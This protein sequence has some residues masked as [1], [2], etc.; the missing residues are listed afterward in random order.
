MTS[1]DRLWLFGSLGLGVA[2]W[3]ARQQRRRDAALLAA[4]TTRPLGPGP[5]DLGAVDPSQFAWPGP[6]DLGPVDPFLFGGTVQPPTIPA[7]TIWDDV[8]DLGPLDPFLLG[9][10]PTIL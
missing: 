7:E 4:V 2:L 5:V 3:N 9:G 1:T 8:P 10:P 6:V